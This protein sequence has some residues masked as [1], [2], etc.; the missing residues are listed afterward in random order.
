NKKWPTI[1]TTAIRYKMNEGQKLVCMCVKIASPSITIPIQRRYLMTILKN[2][3]IRII[4]GCKDKEGNYFTNFRELHRLSFWGTME[5][6]KFAAL[7]P[8]VQW[9]E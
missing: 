1:N 7:G 8:V 5:L 9:I 2:F 4:E 3:I 6:L